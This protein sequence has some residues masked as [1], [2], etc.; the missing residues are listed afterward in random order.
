[1]VQPPRPVVI[2]FPVRDTA[3][4]DIAPAKELKKT[5]PNQPVSQHTTTYNATTVTMPLQNQN[6]HNGDINLTGL[7]SCIVTYHN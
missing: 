6:A 5:P 4:V 3:I 1:M 2:L 7:L